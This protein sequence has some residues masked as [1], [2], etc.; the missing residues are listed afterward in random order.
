MSKPILQ[1]KIVWITGA[2][3]GIGAAL[4]MEF[5]DKGA[6][7]VLSAPFSE[8]QGLETTR[9]C[10]ASPAE[11][12]LLPFDLTQADQIAAAQA[13]VYAKLG[14]IDI[15]VNNAGITHRSRILETSVDVDRRIMEVN[16]FGPVTLAKH[17][18][19]QMVRQGGGQVVVISSVLGLIATPQRS[20][21]IA[22]K[23]A[24][25]GFFEALRAE[26]AEQGIKVTLV[27]PG[28]VNTDISAHALTGDGGIYGKR[29]PGQLSAMSPQTLARRAVSGII[30]GKPRLLIAGKERA[31]VYLGRL[32]PWLL[33]MIVRRVSVT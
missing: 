5:A 29:D 22:A 33:S 25:T 32:A 3:R 27:F 14:K 11:H 19:P 17:V 24:L 6:R 9:A 12:L 26:T 2:S 20:A 8:M 23:H 16:Y 4:A 30:A 13:E 18:V 15:L 1:G 28:F 31:L 21:Y 10:C 7:L